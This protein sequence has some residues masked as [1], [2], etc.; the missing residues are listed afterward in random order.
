MKNII[1]GF[2]IVCFAVSSIQAKIVTKD[3]CLLKGDSFI[4]AGGECIEY[5]EALSDDTDTLNIVVHGI[6]SEGT[7]TLGRYSVFA[8]DL[9]IQ[10]DIST[11]AVA[12]PGYS[13]SSTNHLNSLAHK[14][15]KYLASTKEYI[16][17]LSELVLSLKNRYNVKVVNYI[18]HSAGAAMGAT[19]IGYNPKLIKNLVS[20]GGYYDIHKRSRD[21]SL[22]SAIDYID[23]IDKNSK[24]LL[25]YGEKDKISK[26]IVSK[27]FY[28]I[29]KAKN[30]N[31]KLVEVKNGVHLDLDMTDTSV[32]N[33]VEFLE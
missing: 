28:K 32:E 2:F 24:I 14:G 12:L 17:F 31:V 3:K 4:Y 11:I 30:I 13:G 16:D 23:N 18:G 8:D 26:P 27:E 10:T 6:W 9:S 15:T 5:Y 33:I 22:I 25:I 21:K 19:L 29:A 7:N 1:V 20:V